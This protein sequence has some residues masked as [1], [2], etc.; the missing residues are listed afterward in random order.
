MDGYIISVKGSA[1]LG[2]RSYTKNKFQRKKNIVSQGVHYNTQYN[3][4]KF[5]LLNSKEEVRWSIR[6]LITS[7]VAVFRVESKCY[8]KI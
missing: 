8:Y 6:I 1:V 5:Y 3:K 7:T 4:V 2:M